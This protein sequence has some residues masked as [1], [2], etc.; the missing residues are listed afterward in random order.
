MLLERF[1]VTRLVSFVTTAGLIPSLQSAYRVNH[2]TET[3]VLRVLSDIL[4]ALHRGDF[5][6]LALLDLSAT[7]VTVDHALHRPSPVADLLRHLRFSA[8]LDEV[9]PQRLVLGLILSALAMGLSH[10]L[11]LI[12]I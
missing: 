8:K 11:S 1:V 7:F 10:N 5:A 6:A 9:V 4:L 2:S 3:A 12:H